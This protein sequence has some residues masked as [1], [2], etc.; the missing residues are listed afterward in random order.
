MKKVGDTTLWSP[1]QLEDLKLWQ[2]WDS[3]GRRPRDF[4]PLIRRIDPLVRT[5][6]SK[7]SSVRHIPQSAIEAEFKRHAINALGKYDPG[8]GVP[9]SNYIMRQMDGAKRFIY[10]YQNIG[11]IPAHR[12][13]KIGEFKSK[14]EILSQKLGRPPTALELADDLRWP[15]NE[16]GRMTKELRQDLLPWKSTAASSAL[17]IMPPREK[18]VIEL[19]PYDLDPRQQAVFEYV[20]G[21]GGKPTLGTGDIARAMKISPSKVSKIKK[22]IAL[23]VDEYLR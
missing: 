22:E 2:H 19:L 5:K 20:Y 12:T 4:H 1:A 11:R 18:E 9:V 8:Y 14:F 10:D 3:R 21:A 15:V 6:A 13:R 17:D 7:F 16:V 23:K